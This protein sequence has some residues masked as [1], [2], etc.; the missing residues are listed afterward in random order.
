[1]VMVLMRWKLG[2]VPVG[3]NIVVVGTARVS[4]DD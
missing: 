3:S 1:M 2:D 4:I